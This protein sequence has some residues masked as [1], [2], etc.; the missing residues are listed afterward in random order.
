GG[1]APAADPPIRRLG[2][3]V[4][5]LPAR[6]SHLPEC[7]AP[8]GRGCVLWPLVPPG[9]PGVVSRRYSSRRRNGSTTPRSSSRVS[10]CHS[11][12][13]SRGEPG[14]EEA[15]SDWAA[16]SASPSSIYQL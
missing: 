4:R 8:E 15:R 14:S 7:T 3:V 11:T 16:R 12:G 1:G 5:R 13:T 9:F 2:G 6:V 10:R